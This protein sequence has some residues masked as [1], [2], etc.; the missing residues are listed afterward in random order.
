LQPKFEKYELHAI[1][2]KVQHAI[3]DP[4]FVLLGLGLGDLPLYQCVPNM[5]PKFSKTFPKA[6]HVFWAS[7][8]CSSFHLQAGQKGIT[9]CFKIKPSIW[10]TSMVSFFWVMSQSNWFIAKKNKTKERTSEVPI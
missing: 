7:G 8:N 3:M 1:N 5:F 6:S 2:E 9:P 10:G 4:N